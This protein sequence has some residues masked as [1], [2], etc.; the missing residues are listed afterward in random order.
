MEEVERQSNTAYASDPATEF[1]VVRVSLS[2]QTSRGAVILKH[3]VSAV[4]DQPPAVVVTD[5][6]PHVLRSA[7]ATG[8][9]TSTYVHVVPRRSDEL[10]FKMLMKELLTPEG[11][12][13]IMEEDELVGG[14][15]N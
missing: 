3:H 9:T 11:Y 4:V 13:E 7:P 2:S 15:Y 5:R 6:G 12:A 14:P 1:D 8:T 10:T